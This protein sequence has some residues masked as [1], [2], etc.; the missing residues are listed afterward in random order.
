MDNPNVTELMK[1]GLKISSDEKQF[2]TSTSWRFSDLGKC[3]RQQVLKR[4]GF[5]GEGFSPKTLFI[6]EM[7]HAIE[8]MALSWLQK[9]KQVDILATQV[10][11][12]APQFD[13]RGTADAVARV[14]N[15]VVPIEVKSTRDRALEFRIPYETHRRQAGAYAWFLGLP[16]AVLAYIGRDGTLAHVWVEVTEELKEV[17]SKQWQDLTRY[18]NLDIPD[19]ASAETDLVYYSRVEIF[20]PDRLPYEE[21]TYKKRGPWGPAGTVKKVLNNECG[22]CPFKDHCWGDKT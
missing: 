8:S 21:F 2:P 3:S 10:R 17:I 19:R 12:E 1:E 4:L 18:W 6:F 14:G 22:Y 15:Q 9:N 13:A 5:H 11:V 7:G 20:L 16:R